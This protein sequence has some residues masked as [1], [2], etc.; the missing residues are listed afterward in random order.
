MIVNLA[1]G[2]EVKMMF[3]S[4][5]N[6]GLLCVGG[7]YQSECGKWIQIRTIAV[8]RVEVGEGLS[9]SSQ[10]YIICGKEMD[11]HSNVY[12]FDLEILKSL[13]KI[14]NWNE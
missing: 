13:I 14:P 12:D 8:Q 3:D 6:V 5:S 4:V 11:L 10:K 9:K 1:D 2:G 7:F